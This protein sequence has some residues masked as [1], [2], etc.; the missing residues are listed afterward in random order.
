MTRQI[1]GTGPLATLVDRLPVRARVGTTLVAAYV[2]LALLRSSRDLPIASAAFE[3]V[4][5][6]YDGHRFNPDRLED[7]LTPEG[8]KGVVACEIEAEFQSTK[9]AWLILEDALFYTAF[10]A[11]REIGANP[12]PAV[13]E[14]DEH[15]F[16]ELE[17]HLH[18]VSRTAMKFVLE[19]I[20]QLVQHPDATFAD[21]IAEMSNTRYG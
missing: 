8:H 5:R 20:T 3:L 16:D 19:G 9:A 10:H 1:K 4:R 15:L 12:S 6:W 13:S 7:A 2:A 18:T 11:Y 14:V 21:L 17:K